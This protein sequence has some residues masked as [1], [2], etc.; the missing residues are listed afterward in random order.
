MANH[1]NSRQARCSK[2]AAAEGVRLA[3][4]CPRDLVFPNSQLVGCYM[5]YRIPAD[6]D[7]AGVELELMK[8]LRPDAAAL[9]CAD[10]S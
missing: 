5:L 8:K 10:V 6:G 2:A 9:R 4:P 1:Q 7:A 3:L